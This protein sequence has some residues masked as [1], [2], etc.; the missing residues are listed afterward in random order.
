MELS[1]LAR[2]TSYL[3]NLDKVGAANARSKYY[4]VRPFAVAE[5]PD[6]SGSP[7]YRRLRVANDL[8][9]A[10]TSRSPESIARLRQR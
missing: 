6:S 8:H 3:A 1:R 2:Y 7:M 4:S 5:A 9:P 10:A